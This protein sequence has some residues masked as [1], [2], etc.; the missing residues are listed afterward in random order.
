M[1]ASVLPAGFEAL[2][3]FVAYWARDTTDARLAA[4]CEAS[5][6]DIQAFYDTM[7]PLAEPAIALIDTAPLHDLPPP[8]ATLAKLVLALAQAA[9]AVEMHGQP[10]S[11]GTP[12]PNS[13]R[14]P[15][16]PAPF[17]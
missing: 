16:G 7:L 8:L 4:R 2:A 5:M 11:P 13:V 9:V 3:P 17:A 6:A 12:W 10:C 14:V 1:N 15:G